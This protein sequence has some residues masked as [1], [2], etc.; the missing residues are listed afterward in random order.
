[1]DLGEEKQQKVVPRAS[2]IYS[3]NPS[4]QTWQIVLVK[5]KDGQEC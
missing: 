4:K 3:Q 2:V 5:G 1:M